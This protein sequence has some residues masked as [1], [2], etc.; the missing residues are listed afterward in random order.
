MTVYVHRPEGAT[1]PWL[2]ADTTGELTE[3]LTL[4]II[5][6]F[7]LVNAGSSLEYALVNVDDQ[8]LT[9]RGAVTITAGEFGALIVAKAQAAAAV[10]YLP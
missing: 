2:A 9:R 8:D 4:H 6:Q 7:E 1:G 10:S 3:F 5:E